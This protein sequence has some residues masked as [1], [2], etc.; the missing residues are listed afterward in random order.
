MATTVSITGTQPAE[1]GLQI[2]YTVNGQSGQ[3]ITF[4]TK[5]QAVNWFN[6]N[7]FTIDDALL[8]IMR[9]WQTHDAGFNN[10]NLILGKTL[11]I[12]FSSVTTPV[13]IT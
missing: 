9:C 12:D 5:A 10:I 7:Q 1:N 11:T 8:F 2:N 3:S 6:S 13:T 4:G